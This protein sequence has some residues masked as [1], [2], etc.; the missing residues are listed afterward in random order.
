M[1]AETLEIY[2]EI[3]ELSR[4]MLASAKSGQWD[5]LVAQE[6]KRQEVVGKLK[7]QLENVA[8]PPIGSQAK[9]N[10]LIQEILKLDE[11]TRT[12]TEHCMADIKGSLAAVGVSKQLNNTYLRP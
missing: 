10:A 6:T 3:L 8:R 2:A 5:E 11:E 9:T 1:A 4:R 7:K 12:L